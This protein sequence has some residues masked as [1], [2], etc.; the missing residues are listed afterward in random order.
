MFITTLFV[1]AM[2]VINASSNIPISYCSPNREI[3]TQNVVFRTTQKLRSNDGREL[4]F[5]TNGTCDGFDGDHREFSCKYTLSAGDVRLLDEKGN[6][7]YKGTY[8]MKSDGQ[9]LSNVTIAGTTYWAK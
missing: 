4:Y 5:Y 8:R 1:S 9:N 2:M 3:T 6:T 7:V